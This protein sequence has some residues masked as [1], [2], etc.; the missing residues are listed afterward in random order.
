MVFITSFY[1]EMTSKCNLL[2]IMLQNVKCKKTNGYKHSKYSMNALMLCMFLIVQGLA[3]NFPCG[4]QGRP[5]Y[6]SPFLGLGFN[7]HLLCK[8]GKEFFIHF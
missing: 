8:F 4:I 3:T 5:L 7:W 6:D 2:D 1:W